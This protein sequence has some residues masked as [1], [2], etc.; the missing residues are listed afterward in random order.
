[1]H[2]LWDTLY[3]KVLRILVLLCY[4]RRSIDKNNPR[5]YIDLFLTAQQDGQGHFFTDKDLLI[6]CQVRNFTKI[7]Q[8]SA[9]HRVQGTSYVYRQE[10]CRIFKI[11]CCTDR[12][13]ST[14]HKALHK[15]HRVGRN[16]FWSMS[17]LF[18]ENKALCP[19]NMPKKYFCMCNSFTYFF[20]NLKTTN[21]TSLHCWYIQSLINTKV[22]RYKTYIFECPDLFLL[23]H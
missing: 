1:M 7:K 21:L 2:V 13:G 14:L 3:L 22:Y 4:Y 23:F 18:A 9:N 12:L 16:Y 10:F 8:L 20:V 15:G 6:G 5:G 19:D 17:R 11:I